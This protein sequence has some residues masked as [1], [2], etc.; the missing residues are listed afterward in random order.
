[1]TFNTIDDL[2]LSP[3][4][5]TSRRW[6]ALEGPFLPHVQNLVIGSLAV[7]I[8]QLEEGKSPASGAAV[9]TE[10]GGFVVKTP[11][12]SVAVPHVYKGNRVDRPLLAPTREAALTYLK[13]MRENVASG[14]LDEAILEVA[15]KKGSPK[16][17]PQAKAALAQFRA[18]NS[19]VDTD[20]DTL[21]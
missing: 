7:A 10:E 9:A 15:A 4:F 18:D 13:R 14:E 17:R 1:M 11:L 8:T 19:Q 12:N 6:G 20:L 16:T 21:A 5:G 3:V 2:E